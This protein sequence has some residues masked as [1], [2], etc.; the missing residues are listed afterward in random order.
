MTQYQNGFGHHSTTNTGISLS[1]DSTAHVTPVARVATVNLTGHTYLPHP[2]PPWHSLAGM[3]PF[4]MDVAEATS[5]TAEKQSGDEPEVQAPG[6]TE[7]SRVSGS[8]AITPFHHPED[9]RRKDQNRKP[10]ALFRFADGTCMQSSVPE[11]GSRT[12]LGRKAEAWNVVRV[13]QNLAVDTELNLPHADSISIARVQRL[14][15]ALVQICLDEDRRFSCPES[16][17][18][19]REISLAVQALHNIF[20]VGDE[21]EKD[22][23]EA[24][25]CHC[26]D[27]PGMNL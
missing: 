26:A 11:S 5:V 16:S 24:V 4:F 20:F 27:H 14:T 21:D 8:Y 10:G 17:L 18:L 13:I 7:L 19:V 3:T 12:E 1:S 6:T 25:S 9:A 2:S 23:Q 15:V 22:D